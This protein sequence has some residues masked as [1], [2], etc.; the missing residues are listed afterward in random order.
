MPGF[1]VHIGVILSFVAVAWDQKAKG[2]KWGWG[3]LAQS[4]TRRSG[5]FD[6][7]IAE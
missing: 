1:V 3:K 7:L 2:R 6:G 4:F 5:Y